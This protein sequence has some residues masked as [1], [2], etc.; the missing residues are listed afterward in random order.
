MHFYLKIISRLRKTTNDCKGRCHLFTLG[1]SY[2]GRQLYAVEVSILQG[3]QRSGSFTPQEIWSEP[4]KKVVRAP[5]FARLNNACWIVFD[6]IGPV[7]LRCFR[8]TDTCGPKP[9]KSTRDLLCG[10]RTLMSNACLACQ[11]CYLIL[12]NSVN[13]CLLAGK[14]DHIQWNLDANC[15][16]GPWGLSFRPLRA[17]LLLTCVNEFF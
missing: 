1:K 9:I 3:K 16:L 14:L 6:S 5:Y 15:N 8:A 2:E 4:V 7:S 12:C 11:S 10:S 17:K 13:P